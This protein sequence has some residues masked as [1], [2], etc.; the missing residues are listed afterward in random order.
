MPSL[1]R[2]VHIVS[3]AYIEHCTGPRESLVNIA[4]AYGLSV[5]DLRDLNPLFSDFG[6]S[7]VLP[8]DVVRDHCSILLL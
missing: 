1:F 8:A 7:S 3:A 2:L 6:D 5:S 4:Q